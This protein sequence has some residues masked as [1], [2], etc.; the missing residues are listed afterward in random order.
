M[1]YKIDYDI[2]IEKA[3]KKIPKR[4]AIAIKEKISNLAEDPRPL[5]SIK[6]SGKEDLYR[7]R[8]GDYRIIYSIFDH[9]LVILV[10]EVEGRKDVYKKK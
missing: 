4:D 1:T 9:Q 2:N 8:A 6:L 7:I 3:L 5:G 10:V